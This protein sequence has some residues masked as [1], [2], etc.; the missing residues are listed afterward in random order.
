MLHLPHYINLVLSFQFLVLLSCCNCRPSP[1]TKL[2]PL[3]FSFLSFLFLNNI[4]YLNTFCY[5]SK[6]LSIVPWFSFLSSFTQMRLLLLMPV[7]PDSINKC[8]SYDI[9]KQY[10]IENWIG[11][12]QSMHRILWTY[13]FTILCCSPNVNTLFIS[14]YWSS[15]SFLSSATASSSHNRSTLL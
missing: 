13:H 8:I 14:M 11:H 2:L 3:P 4:C 1:F 7:P 12:F 9:S 6:L 5:Q 15:L 10:I